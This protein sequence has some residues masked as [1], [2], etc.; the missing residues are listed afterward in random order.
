MRQAKRSF[1]NDTFDAQKNNPRT[2][3]K[4]IKS[5]TGSSKSKQAINSIGD[6]CIDDNQQKAN[7]DCHD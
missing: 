1:F 4:T 5:L 2:M 3:W 6:C 7:G